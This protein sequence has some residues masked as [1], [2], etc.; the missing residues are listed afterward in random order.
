MRTTKISAVVLACLLT[1]SAVACGSKK[2]SDASSSDNGVS[3]GEAVRFGRH[4]VDHGEE[5]LVH[6][7][8]HQPL[9]RPGRARLV[10]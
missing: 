7:Q 5:G 1:L 8:G 3:V 9:L 2:N 10:R 4:L 6:H